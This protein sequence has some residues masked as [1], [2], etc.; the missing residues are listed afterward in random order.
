M[1]II[2]LTN[3]MPKPRKSLYSNGF[4]LMDYTQFSFN[5][6]RKAHNNEKIIIINVVF[7]TKK[8]FNKFLCFIKNLLKKIENS[9]LASHI[10]LYNYHMSKNN[11]LNI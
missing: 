3:L 4:I 8:D 2:D 11:S 6:L 9:K 10:A 5:K 7:K 1:N